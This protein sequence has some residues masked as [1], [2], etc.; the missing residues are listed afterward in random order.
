[1]KNSVLILSM[2]AAYGVS[3][4]QVYFPYQ[5]YPEAGFI[6]TDSVNFESS[7]DI[8]CFDSGALWQIGMPQKVILS[9]SWSPPN[10]LITDTILPYPDSVNTFF[11]LKFKPWESFNIFISWNQK[12]D[13]G[14]GDSCL[15]E[16]SSDGNQWMSL[17]E[18]LDYIDG[19]W[20]F[21]FIYY[22]TDLTTNTS[23]FAAID[24]NCEFTDTTTGWTQQSLW[25]H[26]MMTV[27]EDS[28]LF[29]DSMFVRF[30]F[31]SVENTDAHEGWLIDNFYSGYFWIGG[32]VEEI[33]N[34][35]DVSVI[36]NPAANEMHIICNNCIYPLN[37]SCYDMTGKIVIS[38]QLN[39][40]L[41]DTRHLQSGK[42]ILQVSDR[43]GKI[44]HRKIVISR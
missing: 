10:A 41:I 34:L 6:I 44:A 37:I 17:T 31:S 33:D 7:S 27:K 40:N 39:S 1:M 9:Q 43:T 4:Q 15:V 20:L 18:Y 21:E 19:L 29:T 3:A 11:Y 32:N 8:L 2:L 14:T 36:P 24:E 12:V 28:K 38:S 42:Y 25:F 22:K 5:S 13:V 16:V 23:E 35:L 30:R 26:Y